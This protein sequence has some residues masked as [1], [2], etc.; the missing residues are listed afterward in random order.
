MW[1]DTKANL[2]AKGWRLKSE[3]S[4]CRDDKIEVEEWEDDEKRLWGRARERPDTFFPD[5][6]SVIEDENGQQIEW[7]RIQ[8]E[9]AWI[10]EVLRPITKGGNELIPRCR[11]C[12]GVKKRR[13]HEGDRACPTC[14]GKGR[15][16]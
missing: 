12:R 1:K 15:L 16:F 14:G 13:T 11:A 10:S 7:C 6:F 9:C 8:N 5:G 3:Y 2:L 4:Q